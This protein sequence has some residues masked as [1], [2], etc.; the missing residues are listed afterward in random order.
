MTTFS[1]TI[2]LSASAAVLVTACGGSGSNTVDNFLDKLTPKQESINKIVDKLTPETSPKDLLDK[3]TPDGGKGGLYVG[4]FVEADDG[5]DGDVDI[6]AIYLDIGDGVGAS[7]KGRMSY[8][9][10]SCQKNRTLSTDK[11]SVKVDSSLAGTL[12]GSLDPLAKLDTTLINKIAPETFV[13]T[14]FAGKWQEANAGDKQ[15]WQGDYQHQ[16]TTGNHLSSGIKGCPVQYHVAQEGRYTVFDLSYQKG[17]L[18]PIFN[19][20]G[21]TKTL[22]WHNAANTKLTLISQINL[23][24]AASGNNGYVV[25]TVVDAN[26]QQFSPITTNTVTNYVFVIQ[27]FDANNH[28]I[29]FASVI[30]AL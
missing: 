10:Q 2:I 28:L 20:T 9:Q 17:N 4:H 13:K 30:S 7:V 21:S 12:T 26:R 29:G 22:T 25:N 1:K 19:G 8:Q 6:G 3:I 14:T 15:P 16:F 27:N 11:T 23:N 5:D 18:K 24:E